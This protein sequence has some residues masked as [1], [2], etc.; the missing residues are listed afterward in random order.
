MAKKDISKQVKLSLVV[1]MGGFVFFT[2][3]A[4]QLG[5]E[6]NFSIFV[7][8]CIAAFLMGIYIFAV[9]QRKKK[10]EK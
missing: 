1:M 7:A 4:T 8:A 5:L 2:A 10:L 3:F 6:K 9:I